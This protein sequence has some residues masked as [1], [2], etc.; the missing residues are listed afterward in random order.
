M[1]FWELNLRPLD[2]EQMLLTTE[3]SHHSL[4][5]AFKMLRQEE[6]RVVSSRSAWAT[7]PNLDSK[8]IKTR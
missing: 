2:K 5:L 1:C 6:G 3:P 8:N 7:Q 4:I